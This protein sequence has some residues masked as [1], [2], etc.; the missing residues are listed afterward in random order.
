M[1]QTTPSLLAFFHRWGPQFGS[2][3]SLKPDEA[4]PASATLSDSQLLCAE[5]A[6]I[7]FDPNGATFL[8][9]Q[10]DW[11]HA[12]DTPLSV[13]LITGPSGSGKTRQALELCQ[14]LHQEGWQSGF[15][16][17]DCDPHHAA[18]LGRQIWEA[19]HNYCVVLDDA[20]IRQPVLLALLKTV[21]ANREASQHPVQ[22]RVLLLARHEGDWWRLLPGKDS[23]CQA[24]LESAACSG[25][26]P[27]P[28]L[29]ASEAARQTAYQLALHTLAQGLKLS[30]PATQPDLSDAHFA[31][32]LYLQMA[33]LLAVR[34]QSIPHAH[35]LASAVLGLEQ[36]YWHNAL[37]NPE[38]E[39]AGPDP[40]AALLMT[41]ATLCRGIVSDRDVEPLWRALGQDKAQLKN[42]FKTLA[43]LYNG[44]QGLQGLRPDLLGEA[45]VAHTLSGPHGAHMLN[46]VLSKDDAQ[47]HHTSLTLLARV[48]PRHPELTALLETALDHHLT[49]CAAELLAVCVETP[50]PLPQLAERVYRQ[51]PK[52]Q[53]WQIAGA[54][55]KKL[56]FNVQPLLALKVLLCE[57][58]L[59]KAR[60]KLNPAK[61]QTLSDYAAALVQLSVALHYHGVPDEAL[62]FSRQAVETYQSLAQTNPERFE[63]DWALALDNHASDLAE[64]GQHQAALEATRQ[65]QDIYQRLAQSKPAWYLFEQERTRLSSAFWQWLATQ[66]PMQAA[67]DLPLLAMPSPGEESEL[68]FQWATLS[69]LAQAQTARAPN[70]L[71]HALRCWSALDQEQQ[72]RWEDFYFLLA[73]LTEH[74]LGANAAPEGWRSAWASHA[75]KSRGHCP[76]WMSDVAQRLGFTF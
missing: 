44:R 9:T 27:L 15:L 59:E 35:A 5:E 69:A 8:Q 48:L 21:L 3:T 1:T 40:Q 75:A 19:H 47:L 6:I 45:L 60:Q 14:R 73:A 49:S 52:Q 64:H 65:A 63:P 37:G 34:G 18:A 2:L 76:V 20:D 42:L 16:R 11:A 58:V 43:P 22:V 67:L 71:Q 46:A 38:P 56:A 62:N 66:T 33:A 10:L 74:K 68:A 31:H 55:G 12:A 29:Y 4:A 70:T 61:P 23:D 13:R 30:A 17:S 28:A 7:A 51:L 53:R 39:G 41:L 26:V 36:N 54:V 50:S 25:P 72:E 57:N 24:L 32:P